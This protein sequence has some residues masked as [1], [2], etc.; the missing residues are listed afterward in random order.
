MKE[1]TKHK[2]Y[3]CS[4]LGKQ[5]VC[6]AQE[7]CTKKPRI[8]KVAVTFVLLVLRVRSSNSD[9]RISSWAVRISIERWT[10]KAVVL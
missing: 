5:Y 10:R 4:P 3:K 6:V 1:A 8:I 2:M 9:R 7:S